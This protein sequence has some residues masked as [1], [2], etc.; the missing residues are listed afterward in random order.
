MGQ[1][2]EKW[3]NITE[4][5]I[6][7]ERSATL[8]LQYYCCY[9]LPVVLVFSDNYMYPHV[10]FCVN[11][12]TSCFDAQ[13]LRHSIHVVL[14]VLFFDK[15]H[16]QPA[17]TDQQAGLAHI[18]SRSIP[19]LKKSNGRI[20]A[21]PARPCVAGVSEGFT[22]SSS[23]FPNRQFVVLSLAPKISLGYFR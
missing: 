9:L 15:Q 5:Y 12:I 17:R 20:L 11:G 19:S 10:F 16:N 18:W 7:S 8:L 13:R 14:P 23:P 21:I 6:P 22:A 2:E 1:A 3:S 4:I